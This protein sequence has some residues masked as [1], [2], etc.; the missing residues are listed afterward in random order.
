MPRTL[1]AHADPLRSEVPVTEA[2]PRRTAAPAEVRRTHRLGPSF[3]RVVLGGE[4]L[5]R[6]APLPFTDSYVKLVFL[7]PGAPQPLPLDDGRLDVGA[8]RAHAPA[9]A[10]PRQRAYTVR[11]WDA[12]AGEL[13]LDVVVHG[14]AGLGGAWAARARP[15]E[16]TW[17]LGPGGAY[18][19]DPTADRHLLVG[20][21]SALP[22][23]AVTLER[24]PA[25]SRALALVEVPGADDELPI[26]VA[27]GAH[28]EVRW[29]HRGDG[30]VGRELVAAVR[31]LPWPEGRT[32]AFVHGEAGFVAELRRHLRLE[33]RLPRQDLSISG[34]W[35]L[36]A[37]DE[38]WR[39]S[40]KRWVAELD[41]Q[42][43]KAGID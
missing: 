17:V 8:L 5:A 6:F 36:G 16:R 22:A 13:T 31:D 41:A 26:D 20:D 7:D 27:P 1:V 25:G 24:L 43:E 15:G 38:G 4:G 2:Q 21:E 29:L 11:R 40:K 32:E 18:A 39:A 34:Y 28:A 19:P 30:V 35:R 14:D 23:I 12:D 3:V 33:R 9:D 42:E 37:D 10:A